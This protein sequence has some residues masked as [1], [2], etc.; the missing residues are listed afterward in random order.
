MDDH[1]LSRSLLSG[2]LVLS[3]GWWLIGQAVRLLR[4]FVMPPRYVSGRDR[5][6][7]RLSEEAAETEPA[8]LMPASGVTVAVRNHGPSAATSRTGLSGAHH[9]QCAAED[10]PLFAYEDPDDGTTRVLC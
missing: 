10:P 3:L 9:T 2:L 7:D 1:R 4:S 5:S 6:H 8:T